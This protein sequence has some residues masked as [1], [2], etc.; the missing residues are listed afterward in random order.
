MRRTN[1]SNKVRLYALQSTVLFT[2]TPRFPP[3]LYN[4]DQQHRVLEP[5]ISKY[6]G[7]SP[8]QK[9]DGYVCSNHHSPRALIME[10]L[11]VLQPH[12]EDRLHLR[13]H[14]A[15]SVVLTAEEYVPSLSFIGAPLT[16]TDWL[17]SGQRKEH[18]KA[19]MCEPP[20]ASFRSRS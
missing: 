12:Q 19:H 5:A 14:R 4:P 16:L 1:C 8:R 7:G 15:R 17:K 20:L 13:L 6:Y 10:I 2:S 3:R 11:N 9:Y 18:S